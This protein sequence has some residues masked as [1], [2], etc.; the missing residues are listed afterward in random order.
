MTSRPADPASAGGALRVAGQQRSRILIVVCLVLLTMLGLRLLYVQGIDPTGQA[1]AAMAERLRTQALK[2]ERGSILDRDGVVLA[3]SVRRYDLVVDQRLVKDQTVV[4]R[5]TG[6]LTE[7]IEV[8]PMIAQLSTILAVPE[9]ELTQRM[10]GE[11]AYAVVSRSVTP[12]VRD[13]ALEIGIPGLLAEPVDRRLYPNG[14][15]A[16]S[17]LGFLSADGQPREG[18]EVSQNEILR[19]KPGSRRY[20]VSATGVRIPNA[21][22]DET[23]AQDGSDL[24]LTLDMD[25]QWYAQELIAAKAAEFQ[26]EWANIVVLDA[27][28]GDILVMAD[29]TTVDPADPAATDQMFWRPTALTQAFEPGSTGKALTMAASLDA[30]NITPLSEYTVPSR[31]E[32]NGQVINDASPHPTYDM[33]VAGIF[34]R[35]YNVGTIKVSEEITRQQRYDY[36]R[37]FGIGSPIRLGMPYEPGGTL[38]DPAQWDNRQ[39]LTTT[40]GQGYTQTTLH[41]AQMYQAM[42]N[43]GVLQPARLIDATID[44][45][46]AEHRWESG[47]PRQ[48]IGADTADEMLRMMETVVTEGTSKNAAL[49][50]Y[51]V[52]G[53]SSTAQAAGPSGRYD[54]FN[55]GFTGVAPLDDPRYVV[56]V[57]MH[58]PALSYAG[59]SLDATAADILSFLLRQD[60]VPA[61]DAEPEDYP[62]FTEDPQDRPW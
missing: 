62:V 26:A 51:R 13:L 39:A 29:S 15:V 58:R 2:P 16:G 8:Q 46:G 17:V 49:E 27:K 41:T 47:E 55:I 52:G 32:F 43:G 23:P 38:V 60:N 14:A 61:S 37:A 24:R 56:S 25:A 59:A 33:T 42:A 48:V 3:T 1:T 18:I 54:G 36:M 57:S 34:A 9:D 5:Q 19:G 28:T 40:F 21:T 12:Q 6:E 20:E 22:Y 44:A 10:T 7:T 45:S 4:N 30:S 50:G 35:S 11:R 31:E 53:K